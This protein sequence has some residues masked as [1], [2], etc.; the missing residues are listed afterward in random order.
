MAKS[1]KRLV[2]QVHEGL[3]YDGIQQTDVMALR[4]VGGINDQFDKLGG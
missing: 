3:M 1:L 2:R 4:I